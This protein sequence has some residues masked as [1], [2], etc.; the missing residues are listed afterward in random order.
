MGLHV[1]VRQISAMR[2]VVI[3]ALHRARNVAIDP[4]RPFATIDYRTAEGLG[5]L[6]N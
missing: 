3:G 6:S 2:N 4:A 1:G 5:K